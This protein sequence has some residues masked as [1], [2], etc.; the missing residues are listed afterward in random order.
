MARKTKNDIIK[1]LLQELNAVKSFY[2]RT[3][4]S[5]A[6]KQAQA[7]VDKSEPVISVIDYENL[8]TKFYYTLEEYKELVK[9]NK[10]PP[11]SQVRAAT[12]FKDRNRER[13]EH[14]T[15]V[16]EQGYWDYDE[17]VDDGFYNGM[18][19]W[20]GDEMK[21]IGIVVNDCVSVYPE[22]IQRYIK[23]IYDTNDIDRKLSL[24]LGLL[25][26]FKKF[27]PKCHNEIKYSNGFRGFIGEIEVVISGNSQGWPGILT[28]IGTIE[29]QRDG[30]FYIFTT[31]G[32]SNNSKHDI[33][34]IQDAM[35]EAKSTITRNGIECVDVRL[36]NKED[37]LRHNPANRKAQA[38]FLKRMGYEKQI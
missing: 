21:P 3:D 28:E 36:H 8:Q 32:S 12:I 25:A 6:E 33:S 35:R 23:E 24:V 9:N 5:E 10:L 26:D 15:F 30:K 29:F 1:D 34:S 19:D 2:G 38:D 16:Y 27:L 4:V 17:N 31:S 13:E 11:M 14:D 7:I 22:H 20:F 18:D 37:Q